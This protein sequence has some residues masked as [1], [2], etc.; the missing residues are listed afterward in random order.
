MTAESL[1]ELDAL[2]AA[3]QAQTRHLERAHGLD[4]ARFKHER[5]RSVRGALRPLAIGLWVQALL[6]A[7]LIVWFAS[8]WAE[9]RTTP[10]LF[11][12]GVL[13]HVWSVGLVA[14]AVR[15]LATISQID[16]AAPVLAIQKRIAELRARRIRVAPYYA[17][18][19][20]FMWIPVAIVFFRKYGA[21]FWPEE[22]QL[23]ARFA[24]AENPEV[25]AWLV[26]N[27]VVVPLLL[28]LFLRWARDPKRTWLA[29]RIDDEVVG[30]SVLRAESMLA[31]IAA[32]E[33]E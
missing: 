3:W 1:P 20:C 5:M 17:V 11:V 27:C 23:V 28:L 6:G 7:L 33:R 8:F 29:K 10:Q 15:D 22:T 4:L 13:G 21:V 9:H 25:I 30:R 31:E 2:K 14:F 19:G 24:W 12:L 26:A 16:Y 32:F 18:T